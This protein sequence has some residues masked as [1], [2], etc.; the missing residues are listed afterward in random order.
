LLV[1]IGGQSSL[2]VRLQFAREFADAEGLIASM[3]VVLV[4]GVLV[5]SVFF[6]RLEYGIRERRGLVDASAAD[7]AHAP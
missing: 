2:G 6:A 7:W 5:D 3:I 1:I 4:I